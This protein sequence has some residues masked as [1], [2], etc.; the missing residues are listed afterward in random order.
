[1]KWDE[2][3]KIHFS[4]KSPCKTCI[5]LDFSNKFSRKRNIQ[6]CI[7]KACWW[8]AETDFK[9]ISNYLH[10]EVNAISDSKSNLK[11]KKKK[12]KKIFF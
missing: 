4:I 12:K 1:M 5:Y 11:K 7:L 6:L 3:L 2:T 8:V 10:L 9:W